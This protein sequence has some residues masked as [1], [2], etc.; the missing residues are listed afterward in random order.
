MNFIGFEYG[1]KLHGAK[2]IS[3]KLGTHFTGPSP[4]E[5][6]T[7]GEGTGVLTEVARLI[8]SFAPFRI[9]NAS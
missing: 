5:V 1:L 8:T 7:A 9:S 6:Y 2:I 4:L 3:L